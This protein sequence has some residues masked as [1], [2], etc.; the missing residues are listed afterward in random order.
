MA[1]EITGRARDGVVGW[2]RQ[3][4]IQG[5]SL[6]GNAKGSRDKD[7]RCHDE[8]GGQRQPKLMSSFASDELGRASVLGGGSAR[9]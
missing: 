2:L 5:H 8:G 4:S 1:G 7:P 6:D 9:E 3:P